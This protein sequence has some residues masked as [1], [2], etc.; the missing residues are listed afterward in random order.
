M[1]EPTPFFN[2]SLLHIVVDYVMIH[3]LIRLDMN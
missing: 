1:N 2:L 3:E